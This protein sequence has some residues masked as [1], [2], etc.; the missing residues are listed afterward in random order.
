MTHRP[1]DIAAAVRYLASPEAAVVTGEV[2]PVSGG[3]FS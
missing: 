1:S 2:L 3:R